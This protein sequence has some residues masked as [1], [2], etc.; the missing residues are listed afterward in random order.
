V[1]GSSIHVVLGTVA[2]SLHTL[3]RQVTVGLIIWVLL[4]YILR[5]FM[6]N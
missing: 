3:E 5:V 4:C 2:V 1:I 6:W